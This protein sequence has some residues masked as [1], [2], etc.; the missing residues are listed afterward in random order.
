MPG[1]DLATRYPGRMVA[2]ILSRKYSLEELGDIL[3]KNV[4]KGFRGFREVDLVLKQ[5][6][7]GFNTPETT[8]A[9]RV[10]DAIAAL[11]GVCYERTYEG[12]PAIKLEALAVRGEACIDIP[13]IIAEGKD[14][15]ELDTAELLDAVLRAKGKFS[16]ADIAASAQK[17]LAQGLAEMAVRAAEEYKLDKIGVS[18]GVAYNDAMVKTIRKRIEEEGLKFLVHREVPCGD[19]GVALGQAAI[20]SR[21]P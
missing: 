4:G 18:G 5:L 21:K 9:G 10:L 16:R 2:G 13:V 14:G 3:I 6:E 1:G 7:R 11:L 15:L 20:A 19:G 17:A 8:S 12:E